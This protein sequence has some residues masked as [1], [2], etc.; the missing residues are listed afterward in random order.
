MP[1]KEMVLSDQQAQF[2]ID[3]KNKLHQ[4][5]Q[6][7]AVRF[8]CHGEC[9]KN[10]F[11]RTSN[12]E[13]GLNYLCEGYKLFFKYIDPYMK[14]MAHELQHQRP[15]ANV[16]NWSREKDQGFPSLNVG[17]NDPCPCGSGKK[18]KKCCGQNIEISNFDA[19]IPGKI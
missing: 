18:F 14:F 10:R 13:Q 17:R 19:Q 2:G 6:D 8:A 12:G 4:Y 5:C 16:M 9:P 7:C 11:V 1:L 3:K 15:P